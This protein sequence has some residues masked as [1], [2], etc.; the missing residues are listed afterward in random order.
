VEGRANAGFVVGADGVV[1]VDALG[2]PADGERLV[3]AI[4]SVTDRPI[5]T[6]VLTHHHPDHH[7]G[8]V[9]L[10]RA[11]ARVLAHPDRSTLAAAEGDE[12]LV[13]AWTGVV[14]EEAMRGFAFADV[15][16]APVTGDTALQ[17][18]GRRIEVLSLP[19]AHTPADLAVWLPVERV[20]FAGDLVVE[21]GVAMVV[22]GDSRTLLAA[23]DRLGALRARILVPGHGRI[24]SDPGALL[25]TTRDY[26]VGLRE[27]MRRAVAGGVPLSRVLAGLPPVDPDRPVSR[28][29]REQRNAVRVYAE[30]EREAMGLDAPAASAPRE[31]S[32]AP[33]GAASSSGGARSSSGGTAGSSGGA[34]G[35]ARSAPAVASLVSAGE[36]AD[37]IE[38]GSVTAI[39]VRTDLGA[40][41]AGHLPGAVHLHTETL[42][43][44]EGGVPNLVLPLESYRTIFSRLG[45]TADRPVAV[46]GSGES[47]NIDATYVAWILAGLGHPGV[48]I[49]DGGVR[50][51]ELDG[52]PLERR[53]PHFEPAPF[54]P[55]RFEPERA[56]L[57]DV[58]RALGRDDVVLVDARPPDQY[59]GRAGPQMRRGHIPGAVNRHWEADLR[60]DGLAKTWRPAEELRAE[61]AAR[62]VTPDREV[63]AYC[64]GGLESSH[65][66]FTLRALLGFPRVRVY[67]GSFTEWAEREELPVETGPGS[68]APRR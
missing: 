58:R 30:L 19:G 18:G 41:L 38:R 33:T 8:A 23:L 36:L 61:Y 44:G 55:S 60:Q 57:E 20:L 67:D 52:R 45:V 15:P 66:H 4:R 40:Y 35:P 24:P 56:T 13:R 14:G 54:A 27:R 53:Y 47:R 42:R 31:G 68:P 32:Q 48:R 65:V 29:S 17:S 11:G 59:A 7:F 64:N 46:Y 62:G 37:L 49:L 16:D 43:A 26:V 50:A 25:G 5:R 3:A 34:A 51:W 2:S 6:L 12:V 22:D 39:D 21:D 28:A 9:A 10:R 63:I 1:V